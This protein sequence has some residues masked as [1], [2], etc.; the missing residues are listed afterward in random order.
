MPERLAKIGIEFIVA[1]LAIIAH[2]ALLGAARGMLDGR[3]AV[4]ERRR[5]IRTIG[6]AALAIVY[7]I[8]RR[9]A[10]RRDLELGHFM[11]ARRRGVGYVGVAAAFAFVERASARRAGRRRDGGFKACVRTKPADRIVEEH[12]R[13]RTHDKNARDRDGA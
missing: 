13:A 3:E 1:I 2:V 8:A 4:L 9:A 5:M 12:K 10:G 6:I 11:F 7:H